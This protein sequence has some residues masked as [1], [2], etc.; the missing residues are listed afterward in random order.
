MLDKIGSPEEIQQ[1]SWSIVQPWGIFSLETFSK[2]SVAI[3]R[4]NEKHRMTSIKLAHGSSLCP[5]DRNTEVFENL[6]HFQHNSQFN[7]GVFDE[8]DS[9]HIYI[10]LSKHFLFYWFSVLN[11]MLNLFLKQSKRGIIKIPYRISIWILFVL[12]LKCS[13]YYHSWSAIN[14]ETGKILKNTFLF[15]S[16][17]SIWNSLRGTRLYKYQNT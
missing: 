2:Q 8:E 14:Q 1:T 17:V 12:T 11:P 15:F 13:K 9:F 10:L 7:W 16:M 5:Y 4:A 3:G 6:A